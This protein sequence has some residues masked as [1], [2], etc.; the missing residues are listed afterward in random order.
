M[1]FLRKTK[2]IIT[3]RY[4]SWFIYLA[5]FA[6]LLLISILPL[7]GNN[8]NLLISN[9]D[10][11]YWLLR[12]FT[13]LVGVNFVLQY[14]IFKR[15]DQAFFEFDKSL[16]NVQMEV[17]SADDGS[18]KMDMMTITAALNYSL[19]NL[20]EKNERLKTEIKKNERLSENISEFYRQ[21]RTLN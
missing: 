11:F 2:R 3:F 21:M 1:N 6:G 14:F 16:T 10:Y 13:V 15:H 5:S 18:K 19:E 4:I 8:T 12:I 9:P 20:N 17:L 7:F